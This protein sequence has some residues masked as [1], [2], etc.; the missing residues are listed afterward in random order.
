IRSPL[1]R[2]G[3]TVFGPKPRDYF[4]LAPKAVRKA[5]IRSA[6]SA[7]LKEGD[8]IVLDRLELERPSTKAFKRILDTLGISGKALFVL[9]DKDETVELSARNLPGVKI[10]PVRG[11]NV[12]DLLL[13][14]KLILTQ[15]A[16]PLIQEAW[17]L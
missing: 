10:L 7:K 6:L 11:L 4:Y 1:W 16:I 15:E 13:Y 12:Y 8:L 17:A 2:H 9:S 3:G 14:E 5:A